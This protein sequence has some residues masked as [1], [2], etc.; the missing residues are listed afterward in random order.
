MTS[1]LSYL[2]QLGVTAVWLGPVFKQRAPDDSYH[3]YAIQDFLDVDP[4]FG[5]RADLVELVGAAHAAGLRVILDVIFNHTGNN[6]VYEGDVDRPSY[7]PWP[8][9]YT[10]GRWR[11]RT[12]LADV[13]AG[14]DD[15]VVAH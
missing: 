8:G 10:R 5:T 12:G 13:I 7:R 1:K 3:G 9:F 14:P 4:R 2:A 11:T 6:W 15:G